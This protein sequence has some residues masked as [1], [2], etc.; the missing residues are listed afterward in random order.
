MSSKTKYQ[1]LLSLR[2]NEDCCFIGDKATKNYHRKD[3]QCPDLYILKKNL[4][5][6]GRN[7]ALQGYRPCPICHPERVELPPAQPRS[8]GKKKTRANLTQEAL[9]AAAEGYGLHLEFIGPNVYVTTIA[10]EWYFNYVD[11][12]ILLHHKNNRTYLNKTGKPKNYYH[13][14]EISFPSPLDAIK[15]IFRHERAAY[16]RGFQDEEDA[17]GPIVLTLSE[18]VRIAEKRAIT[19]ALEAAKGSK[20]KAAELLGVSVHTLYRK[21]K[22]LGMSIQTRRLLSLADDTAE[23]PGRPTEVL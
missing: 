14:Q 23:G 22:L 16:N 3:S 12:P 4:A 9:I 8:G 7:P 10:G 21:R 1:R 6:L 20:Q 19:I 18:A 5:C 2:N 15:Y 17:C 11:R 13:N